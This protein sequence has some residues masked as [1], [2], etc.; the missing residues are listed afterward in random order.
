[1]S[2]TSRGTRPRDH[3]DRGEGAPLTI[4]RAIYSSDRRTLILMLAVATSGWIR[5]RRDVVFGDANASRD[6]GG[7]SVEFMLLEI[8]GK[9]EDPC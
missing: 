9:Q 5:G 4:A 3:R 7:Y 2:L 1:M 8:G 6:C